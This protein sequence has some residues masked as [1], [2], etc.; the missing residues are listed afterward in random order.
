MFQT[1]SHGEPGNQFENQIFFW[2]TDINSTRF[3]AGDTVFMKSYIVPPYSL[4]TSWFDTN[5][6]ETKSYP[7]AGDSLLTYFIWT[8]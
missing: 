5:D 3:Q 4:Q 8:N 6:Y 2:G 7:Y 1:Y